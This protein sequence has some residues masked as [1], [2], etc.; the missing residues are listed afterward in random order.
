MSIF[1]KIPSVGDFLKD[2]FSSKSIFEKEDKKNPFVA[3]Y[4]PNKPK[5]DNA[6]ILKDKATLLKDTVKEIP[7]QLSKQIGQPSIRAYFG[8][9]NFLANRLS[10]NKSPLGLPFQIDLK[11]KQGKEYLAEGPFQAQG[12][13]QKD[14]LGTEAPLTLG[15]IGRESRGGL[16]EGQSKGVFKKI[17][18]AIGFMIGALD[19]TPGGEVLSKEL[20]A[21]VNTL[22]KLSTA[23]EVTSFLSKLKVGIGADTAEEIAKTKSAS[24]I[25]SLLETDLQKQAAI[26]QKAK[27]AAKEAED[28]TVAEP[29]TFKG[30]EYTNI[31]S[32]AS[33][34]DIAVDETGGGWITNLETKPEFRNK[35]E[36][37]KI[38]TKG[39]DLLKEKGVTQIRAIPEN[40]AS[41]KILQKLGFVPKDGAYVLDVSKAINQ[42]ELPN[43]VN[44]VSGEEFKILDAQPE[45]ATIQSTKTGETLKVRAQDL[46]AK[47][48]PTSQPPQVPPTG[49]QKTL[50]SQLPGDFKERSLPQG[51]ANAKTLQSEVQGKMTELNYNVLHNKQLLDKAEEDVTQNADKMREWFLTNDSVGDAAYSNA[52]GI[53]LIEN[54]DN[55]AMATM[56]KALKDELYQ[57]SADIWDALARRATNSGQAVQ[58]LSNVSKQNPAVRRHFIKKTLDNLN[59]MI[60]PDF[61][62]V[63]LTDEDNKIIAD[64]FAQADAA[65][66]EQMK[67]VYTQKAMNHITDKFA[68][69]LPKI[70]K[71]LIKT[72]KYRY[73]SMLLNPKTWIRNIL[74]NKTFAQME[75]VNN[76]FA[77]PVDI[78]LSKKTG[79]RAVST[80]DWSV[81]KKAAKEGA[82]QARLEI[83]EG[84][85][86]SKDKFKNDY[87]TIKFNSKIMRALDRMTQRSLKVPDRAAFNATFESEVASLMKANNLTE[88]TQEIV[89]IATDAAE[90]RTFQDNNYMADLFEKLRKN[91]NVATNKKLLEMMGVNE[92][93]RSVYA[94]QMI[95]LGDL[96]VPFVRTPFNLLSRGLSYTPLGFARGLAFIKKTYGLAAKLEEIKRLQPNNKTAIQLIERELLKTQRTASTALSRG[97]LGTGAFVMPG[98]F[99]AKKGIITDKYSNEEAAVEGAK[100]KIGSGPTRINVSALGRL[101][102]PGGGNEEDYGYQPG[103][104]MVSYDWLMPASIPASIGVSLSKLEDGGFLKKLAEVPAAAFGTIEDQPMLTALKKLSGQGYGEG[105]A[106]GAVDVFADVPSS[107]VPTFFNQIR[108]VVDTKK[109]QVKDNSMFKEIFINKVANRIPFL[110]KVLAP[111]VDAFGNIDRTMY[112]ADKHNALL[113]AFNAMVNPAF[114]STI[115]KDD[116]EAKLMLDLFE[117]TGKQD[118]FPDY[119]MNKKTVDIIID[120]KK[121]KR[122]ITP[123][124]RAQ[125]Q[126]YIGVTTRA[127]VYEEMQSRQFQ[128]MDPEDQ[129]AVLKDISNDAYNSALSIFL[130]KDVSKQSSKRVKSMVG[131]YRLLK[132]QNKSYLEYIKKQHSGFKP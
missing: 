20:K 44:K 55:L 101:V 24:K 38:V 119:V 82:E 68:D 74:G 113:N 14:L 45:G 41:V 29:R 51:A 42:A 59:E 65:K 46:N 84:V 88:P 83:K 3:Q 125:M 40:D 12:Q 52:V 9:G 2:K 25:K 71:L 95:G 120:G 63:K 18:P 26:A 73:M 58:I 97:V 108:Q 129:V 77:S 105:F 98:Y 107:F 78:L 85:D 103:D 30:V 80:L 49:T 109:R 5:Q 106:Q 92:R 131:Q 61:E 118:Q 15:G 132:K 33:K 70:V 128:K 60:G 121:T 17:D 21:G 102:A 56:D 122:V 31:N 114:I 66:T 47:F 123:E 28:V 99:L 86:I 27:V 11:K 7:N 91:V 79:K 75:R 48:E 32:K 93:A 130:D 110:S 127:L 90:L 16:L 112:N 124:E 39:V 100:R 10:V 115:S 81:Y 34:A 116:K 76:L 62:K 43:I 23:D 36:A 57:K 4:V 72:K 111:Q 54:Y 37:T 117:K 96:V 19:L 104:I 22:K 89:D 94:D 64:F 53:K 6:K 87:P 1:D 126:T 69:K 50:E 67:A 8:L 13:F 35:G